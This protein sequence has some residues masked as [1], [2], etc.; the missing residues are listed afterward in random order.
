MGRLV[1]PLGEGHAR[2]S[3][4]ASNESGTSGASFTLLTAL[5]KWDASNGPM[6]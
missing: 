2:E 6:I 1:A 3:C 5:S 4:C